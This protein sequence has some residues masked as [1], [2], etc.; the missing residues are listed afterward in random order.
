[1][2]LMNR[3]LRW[4]LLAA[5]VAVGACSSSET[6][7]DSEAPPNF[8]APADF[9]GETARGF[10]TSRL[11][12]DARRV[13]DGIEINIPYVY[14]NATGDSV[15]FVNCNE[16]I[17][18][19]LEKRIGDTWSSVWTG[20]SP[21][22]MSLPVVVPPDGEYRDTARVLARPDMD[23]QFNVADPDGTYRLV[24]H[25]VVHSYENKPPLGTPLPQDERTSNEFTLSAPKQ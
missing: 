22:C 6:P 12:Y 20:S 15:Y 19:S 5:V 2:P 10:R 8:E 4:V 21:A 14:R 7:P 17:V 1:M 9:G 24:W 25:G 3:T 23:P 18:P 13:A 16:I 11:H